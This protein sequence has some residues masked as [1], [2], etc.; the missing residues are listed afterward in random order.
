MIRSNTPS[1]T[2][3]GSLRRSF[4]RKVRWSALAVTLAAA[5]QLQADPPEL[6]TLGNQI[7]V[8]TTNERVRLAGVNLSGLED[9]IDRNFMN[10][11]DVATGTWKANVFRLPVKNTYWFH[12]TIGPGYKAK[13]DALIERARQLNVYVIL[14]L[15]NYEKARTADATFWTDAANRYK[16][17]PVVLFGLLNEPHGTGWDIWRNGDSEGPGMQGLL[18]AVRA[19]GANNIVLAGGGEWGYNLSGIM[20]GF[21]GLTNGYALTETTSGN[22]IVYDSHVY[23]WKSNIQLNVGNASFL[24]PVL[25]GEF[26]HPGGTTFS[27]Q[28][29]F[30]SDVTWVPRMMDWV[31]TNNLHWTGWNF[32][33]GSHPAMLVDWSYQPTSYWGEIAR[34]HMQSYADP[35]ALRVVGGTPI[36]I[37][38][39]FNVSQGPAA[40]FNNSNTYYYNVLNGWSGLDLGAPKRITQIKYMPRKDNG[41]LMI[42]GVFQGSNSANFSSG[43]VTLHTVSTEPGDTFVGNTGTYTIVP[44]TDTGTYR[45]VRYQGPAGG[46]SN[47]ASMLFL[48]GDDSGPGVNDNVIIVDNGGTGSIVSPG[49]VNANDSGFHGS[50]W[51]SDDNSGQGTKSITYTPTLMQAGQYEVFTIWSAHPTSRSNAVPYTITHAG[52]STTVPKNQRENGGSWQSLGTYTFNAGDAGNVVVSNTGTTSWVTADAVKFVYQTPVEIF[53]DKA[54][55]DGAG[56]TSSTGWSATTTPTPY[57]NLYSYH[58]GN[59]HTGKWV[60]FTPPIATPGQYKVSVWWTQHANRATNAPI[61]VYHAG[62]S[63]PYTVNQETNG[64]QWNELPG[65]F[66]FAAG[67][68]SATGSVL[69]TNEGANEYVIVDAVRFVKVGN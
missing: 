14:D 35:A 58:D 25:L 64:G 66:T 29:S 12:S 39:L 36:G 50:R 2:R 44:V 21:N 46:Y 55:T 18:N 30:E 37:G 40:P 67:S 47:I 56:I 53:M 65:T 11:L 13:V 28:S 33:N 42:G 22:G 23:P 4:G 5:T 17:N 20:P 24:Y 1:I 52:G 48:T 45:Y 62:G 6:K 3:W 68:N 27:G 9:N 34:T 54:S 32:S 63:T 69:I 19:T 16:N 7:V 51:V 15:H 26:A 59:T 8:K 38:D 31:N 10:S 61:T 57:G 43:V 41:H 49:W 60:R